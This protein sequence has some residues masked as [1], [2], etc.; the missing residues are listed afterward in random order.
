[1]TLPKQALVVDDN[2]LNSRLVAVLLKRLGWSS[3]LASSGE[4]A[5]DVLRQRSF[6]L[7]LLDMRMP[8]LSGEQACRA[9]RDDLGLTG[10]PVVAYTAHSTPEEKQRMLD[11]GF[12]GLLVKPISFADLRAVCEAMCTSPSM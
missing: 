5:L 4:Q 3:E 12:S 7:V 8:G 2:P 11:S 10:L 9:I 1:M 6:D